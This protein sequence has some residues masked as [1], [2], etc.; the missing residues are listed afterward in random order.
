MSASAILDFLPPQ[1][2]A[3]SSSYTRNAYNERMRD[4]HAESVQLAC[5]FA[6]QIWG[7]VLLWASTSIVVEGEEVA[8]TGNRLDVGRAVGIGFDL[9]PQPADQAAHEIAIAFSAVAPHAL[10]NQV[11]RENL[12]T[13]GH[14][15]VQQTEL[16]LRQA[17]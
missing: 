16:E 8:D 1:P 9:L 11:R 10:D 15:Q 4:C 14:Q 13:V 17:A 12:A 3:G 5:R 2:R 6:P 7:R